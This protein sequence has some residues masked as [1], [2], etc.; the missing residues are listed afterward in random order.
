MSFWKHKHTVKPVNS[1]PA[2]WGH[3]VKW[4]HL[5]WS[6]TV[7]FNAN[8]TLKWGHLWI[9]D[10]FDSS[11]GCPYFIGFTVP[12]KK[13]QSNTPYHLHFNKYLFHMKS[14]Y[15]FLAEY[16]LKYPY[17]CQNPMN[18]TYKWTQI[19]IILKA[20]NRSLL[21]L[22]IWIIITITFKTT[23][24]TSFPYHNHVLTDSSCHKI[25]FSLQSNTDC[26]GGIKIFKALARLASNSKFLLAKSVKNLPKSCLCWAFV[27]C[28]L[29]LY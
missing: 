7:V 6:P 26:R 18:K 11:Q 23:M 19:I 21:S 12:V 3:P 1:S 17:L 9:R 24:G 27:Q 20:T 15:L 22:F 10:T 25:T 13:I 28:V 8:Y 29:C 5:I 14:K 16:L 2:K 4:G